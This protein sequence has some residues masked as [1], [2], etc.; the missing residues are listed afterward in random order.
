MELRDQLQE[1]L[2]DSLILEQELGG[3]GMSRVFVA[4]EAALGRKV[5]VKVLPQEMAAG[6]S[7]DRFRRE[8]QLAAQL[9]H[10]HIVPLLSA[11]ETKGLPYFTM[12]YVRGESLRARLLKTGELPLSETVRI[13]REVASALA[14]AHDAGVVHRDIKPDNILI[15]GGSAVVTDFGVAKALTASSGSGGGSGLTSLGVALGTPAYMAPEQATADPSIDRRADIYALGVVAYEMLAGSTPFSGRSP[16]ATL[17]AHVTEAPDPITR[18]RASVPPLLAALVMR[19]LEKHAADR[20]QNAAQ[21]MHELDALTTPSGGVTPTT[22]MSAEKPKP[23]VRRL[24]ITGGT[25]AAV[26]ALAVFATIR[27][28]KQARVDAAPAI[29]VL[30]FENVGRQEGKDFADGMTEEITNRLS[31]LRGLR[32]IGRQSAKGYAGSNKTPQQIATELGVQYVLTGTVRWDS[33]EDGK[34]LVRVS[35]ALLRSDDA[36]QVW[37]EAYQTV[38][39]GM[40]EVQAKVATEV[41]NALNVTLL[42]PEKQALAKPPTANVEAYGLYIRGKDML[43]NSTSIAPIRESIAYLEKATALDDKF[44]LAWSTLAIA[45]TEYFWF[46]GD[47]TSHRLQLAKTALDRAAALDAESPDVHLARG[48]LLY[49]GQRDYA[50]ALR[51]LAIAERLRPNDY[52]IQSFKAAVARRQGKWEE[53]LAGHKRSLELEPR[54]GVMALE[55]A[56]TLV[57]L[58][59]Y[60][61]AEPY[62]DRGILLAP[63]EADAFRA[64]AALAIDARGNVPEAIQHLRNSLTKVSPHAEVTALLQDHTWPA[65]E[66]PSLRKMLIDAKP[67]DVQRGDFYLHKARLYLYLKDQARARA[68]ADSAITSLEL[69]TRTSPEAAGAHAIIAFAQAI[70][71]KR[72]AALRSYARSVELLPLAKDAYV[73]TVR[74]NIVPRIYLALGDYEAAISALEKRVGVPGG[75]S[76]NAVRLDPLYAPLRGNPRFERLIQSS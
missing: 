39:S 66:D 20:P 41:A 14:Y 28:Q 42:T 11:G 50:G 13:L 60:S 67:P 17:A 44:T 18:R 4:H 26:F 6:V 43:E 7:I 73:G 10:P 5:V 21:V 36:T 72:D 29:A 48:I 47:Q 75:L 51:E 31:S 25:L 61:E 22:S 38:L 32:V 45:H 55:V 2:G 57:F 76:R 53:A 74:E 9:Q 54:N 24:L 52:N 49:H 33:S 35:P 27:V 56:A 1:T 23:T 58:A 40:F 71:G 12:P 46:R 68:N 34:V 37:A 65:V 30:P 59:R 62:V 19:C 63:G 16:Q 69:E 64:K 3:G 8:I 15:S 70:L